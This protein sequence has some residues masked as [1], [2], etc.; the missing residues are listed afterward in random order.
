MAEDETLAATPMMTSNDLGRAFTELRARLR[1]Y[2]RK[3]VA[4]PDLAEDL[5]QDVFVKAAST[6]EAEHAPRNLTAWLYAAARSSLADHYRSNRAEL[7]TLHDDPPDTRETDEE[8]LHQALATCLRPLVGQLPAIYRDTLLATDFD[9]R[10]MHTVAAEQGLST[11]AIKSRV[12]RARVMLKERLLNCCHVESSAGHVTDYY[13]RK[14]AV[15]SRCC[16]QQCAPSA[17]GAAC[18][19]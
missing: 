6:M 13:L 15:A 2:L 18:E 14:S 5:V 4:D 12:S 16:R 10:T 8:R 19:R 17:V 3:R 1:H 11:S 7:V 9:G